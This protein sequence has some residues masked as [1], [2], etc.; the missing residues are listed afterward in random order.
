MSFVVNFGDWTLFFHLKKLFKN[1]QNNETFYI[2]ENMARQ[3]KFLSIQT[4][5]NI[6]G[7]FKKNSISLFNRSKITHVEK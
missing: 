2:H 4:D 3:I 1:R 6:K 7:I 5:Q